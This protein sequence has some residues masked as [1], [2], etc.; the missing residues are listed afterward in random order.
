[1]SKVAV[2]TGATSWMSRATAVK[3]LEQDWVVVLG[4]KS[5]DKTDGIVD[6]LTAPG[7][8]FGSVVDVTDPSSVDT[9]VK[10]IEDMHG[11]IDA[12]INIAGGLPHASIA[13]KQPPRR[14]FIETPADE[15]DWVIKANLNGVVNT[16]RSVLPGMIKHKSGNIISIV[17][18]AAFTGYPKMSAYSAA[19][20]GVLAFSKTVA[21]EVARDGI[22]VNCILPG[23]TQS[24]WNPE[25][26]PFNTSISPLGRITSP[27]DVANTISFLI[28]DDASHVTGAC[29]D[30]SGGVALH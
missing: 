12:M 15:F 20:A 3:L 22:R 24:R 30:I 1:M 19:K 2:I 17:S 6:A 13:Q 14:E 26:K 23:F 16:T 5:F 11:S 18:G 9:F 10:R 21:Q 28:S 25:G 29:I 8:A 7:R 27:H 4:G